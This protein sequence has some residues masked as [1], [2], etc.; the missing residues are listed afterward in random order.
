MKPVVQLERTGCGIASVAALVGLSYPKAKAIANSLG[1]FA[2]DETLWSETSHVRKLLSFF[3]NKIGSREFPFRS[4]GALPDLALLA[5]KWHLEKGR[6]YWHWVVFVRENG[7]CYVLDSKKSLR[8][9]RRTDFGR[10]K[11]KWYISVKNTQQRLPTD[12]L[13]ASRR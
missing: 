8:T 4:W 1:I 7:Q 12:A 2:H 5:I 9:N 11:P 6:P 3:G 10:M 13:K